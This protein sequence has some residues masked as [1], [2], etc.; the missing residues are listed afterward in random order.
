[1]NEQVETLRKSE[2]FL[3]LQ[4]LRHMDVTAVKHAGGNRGGIK[5]KDRVTERQR[6][7]RAALTVLLAACKRRCG[8]VWWSV[9]NSRGA[10]G[11]SGKRQ[12]RN[13]AWWT[14]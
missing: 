1:M 7:D 3:L 13:E 14:G 2:A 6:E 8:A 11:L 5:K 4:T 10:D 12:G 9:A